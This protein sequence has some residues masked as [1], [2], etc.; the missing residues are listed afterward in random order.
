[1][2]GENK[3]EKRMIE[4]GHDN[5]VYHETTET[6]RQEAFELQEE[7]SLYHERVREVFNAGKGYLKPQDLY[8]ISK[9]LQFLMVLNGE[10]QS[11]EYLKELE[12]DLGIL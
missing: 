3:Q 1:M 8:A 7:V 2:T 6:Q 12:K 4:E 5:G 11:F 9:L 10:K